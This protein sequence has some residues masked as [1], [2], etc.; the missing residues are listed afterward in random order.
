MRR[1][2]HPRA[3]WAFLILTAA[4]FTLAGCL[5]SG[6]L[7]EKE[8]RAQ[9]EAAEA[10]R[11]SEKE[12]EPAT[13]VW[14]VKDKE[15][16][17]PELR[18]GGQPT[19]AEVRLDGH[20]VGRAP[21]SIHP[22][23]GYHQ[24]EVEKEGYEAWSVGFFYDDDDVLELDY[25]LERITGYLMVDVQP[26]DARLYL[27]G[28]GELNQGLNEVPAGAAELSISRFGYRTLKAR[29]SI[30]ERSSAD[31]GLNLEPKD[32][33]L[34]VEAA[35]A[36]FNPEEPG[37]LG[38]TRLRALPDSYGYLRLSVLGPDGRTLLRRDYPFIKD[39][40]PLELEWDGR[41][42]SGEK[43][44]KGKYTVLFETW[45]LR[46]PLEDGAFPDYPADGSVS[47]D[48]SI[49]DERHDYAAIIS[50]AGG[51]AYCP[52]AVALADAFQLGGAVQG[53][54]VSAGLWFGQLEAQARIGGPGGAKPWELA[55]WLG[56]AALAG[57]DIQ[58]SFGLGTKFTL[59][60]LGAQA[61]RLRSALT[62]KAAI[63]PSGVVIDPY[64][65]MAGL[66][67]G[68]P[69]QIGLGGLD[70]LLCPE[71]SASP[72]RQGLPSS[73]AGD[74]W[75]R[76]WYLTPYARAGLRGR[77]GWGHWGVSAMCRFTPLN[78]AA[79]GIDLPL[80]LA[81]E[82]GMADRSGLRYVLSAMGQFES[83]ES[84]YFLM[85]LSVGGIMGAP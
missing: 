49:T 42:S 81:V 55:A 24:V 83:L 51:L 68:L 6:G 43:L 29:L 44:P 36:A 60:D 39:D 32:L 80:G 18:I 63:Y 46:E 62:A 45:T 74:I 19:G 4:A 78:E 73:A 28:W 17:K 70:I 75:S 10:K 79:F 27:E 16:E 35:P 64:G 25:E 54:Y 26:R 34:D 30:P 48:V 12:K 40:E 7:A 15:P 56:L 76:P 65:N 72:Y 22:S 13:V 59:T 57:E 53:T 37:R 61:F 21:L 47:R 14:P 8:V 66:S 2:D 33:E 11:V 52:D 9:K 5:S 82:A 31:I 71:L 23:G 50:G 77:I 1:D 84:F 69:L 41:S 67:I 3:L 38:R 58:A 85:G 20:Y